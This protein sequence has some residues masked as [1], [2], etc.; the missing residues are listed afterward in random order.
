M[1]KR[2]LSHS[3]RGIILLFVLAFSLVTVFSYSEIYAQ[4]PAEVKSVSFEET[5]I[6][7]FENNGNTDIE[8]IRMWLGSGF[9]F[10]SFKTEKGW[11]GE[12][13]P[14]GVIILTTTE[15]IKPGESVKFGVK[16]DKPKPGINWKIIDVN[17]EQIQTGKTLAGSGG[18]FQTDP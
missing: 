4:K 6:I 12:K 15:P 14:Q 10:K 18:C 9:T 16:T 1:L 5:T 17:N 11:I 13:N 2:M 8:T 3:T 7:E